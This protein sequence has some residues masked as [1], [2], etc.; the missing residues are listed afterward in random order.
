MVHGSAPRESRA[1][2]LSVAG[3]DDTT[4]K[5]TAS[6]IRVEIFGDV[7]KNLPYLRSLVEAVFAGRVEQSGPPG[8]RYGRIST[9]EGKVGVGHVRWH[10][11]GKRTSTQFAS[12]RGGRSRYLP[13]RVAVLFGST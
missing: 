6:Q 7:E 12:Y 1:A 5:V 11:W 3:E 10:R 2:S 9:R 8:K 4:L 13:S